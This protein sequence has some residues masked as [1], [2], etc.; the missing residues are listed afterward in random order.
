MPEYTYFCRDA[1]LCVSNMQGL[2]RIFRHLQSRSIYVARRKV[3]RLYNLF[4]QNFANQI[5]CFNLVF[6]KLL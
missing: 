4:L 2:R 6:Y 3:L 5:I 1:I